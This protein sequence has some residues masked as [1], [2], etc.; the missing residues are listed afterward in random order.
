VKPPKSVYCLVHTVPFTFNVFFFRSQHFD[1]FFWFSA[2]ENFFAW[3]KQ[4]IRVFE[5]KTKEI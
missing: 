5:E 3:D 1:R 4:V 2:F